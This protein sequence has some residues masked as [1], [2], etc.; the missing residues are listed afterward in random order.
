MLVSDLARAGMQTR[1]IRSCVQL[2]WL[3][4]SG[5]PN[6]HLITG[7]HESFPFISKSSRLRAQKHSRCF[8]VAHYNKIAAGPSPQGVIIII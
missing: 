6:L 4:I 3:S 2:N 8:I 5:K 7:A 1:T